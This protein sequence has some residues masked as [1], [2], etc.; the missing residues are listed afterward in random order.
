V[1]DV[2]VVAATNRIELLEPA[3]LRSRRF[4]LK[5]RVGLPDKGH[6]REMLQRHAQR[7]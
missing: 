4:D 3:L 1:E 2:V 5:I 7:L 6:R